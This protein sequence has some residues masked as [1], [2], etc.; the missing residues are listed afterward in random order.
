MK[1]ATP[2][3][4]DYPKRPL[5]PSYQQLEDTAQLRKDIL[6]NIRAALRVP[7]GHSILTQIGR[8]KAD[9]EMKRRRI[10]ELERDLRRARTSLKSKD[11]ILNRWAD[12]FKEIADAVGATGNSQHKILAAIDKVVTP[13]EQEEKQ[14][15]L[16]SFPRFM[17]KLW[18]A[19]YEEYDSTVICENFQDPAVKHGG[20]QQMYRHVKHQDW[21]KLEIDDVTDSRRPSPAFICKNCYDRMAKH[22]EILFCTGYDINYY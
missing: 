16:F 19:D 13:P 15:T 2:Y 18:Q 9:A 3:Y 5:R 21:L 17:E 22:D 20:S 7:E 14:D 1:N 6:A 11:S 8:D 12:D 10:V 4:G